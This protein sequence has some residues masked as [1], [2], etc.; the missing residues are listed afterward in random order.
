MKDNISVKERKIDFLSMWK[1]FWNP[2]PEEISK[3]EQILADNGI[4]EI[5]KR[6]LLKALE[7]VDKLGNKL[8]EKSYRTS[9]Q[10]AKSQEDI[11]KTLKQR[12]NSKSI[13]IE[14]KEHNKEKENEEDKEKIQEI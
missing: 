3:E 13:K 14:N 1:D 10:K 9:I 12:N 8:F 2:T 5:E 7:D 11:K 4:S 6:E